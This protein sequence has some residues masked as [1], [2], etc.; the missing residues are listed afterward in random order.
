ML[1]D[2]CPL[3]G[4]PRGSVSEPSST[5]PAYYAPSGF[6]V[7]PYTLG[8]SRSLTYGVSYPWL[9]AD[10]VDLPVLRLAIAKTLC[11]CIIPV[12]CTI[13]VCGGANPCFLL[14]TPP[15]LFREMLVAHGL[16]VRPTT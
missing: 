11:G 16:R 4:N 9:F 10:F 13:R 2:A 8:E 14:L 1:Q 15:G 5:K 12:R 6:A 7:Q 3:S